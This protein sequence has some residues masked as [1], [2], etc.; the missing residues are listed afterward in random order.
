MTLHRLAAMFVASALLVVI[1][2]PGQSQDAKKSDDPFAP[3]AK[4]GNK[5]GAWGG[6]IPYAPNTAV[7]FGPV[8]CPVAVI[9][10]DVWDFKA[11]KV[12]G[13]VEAPEGNA[14]RALSADGKY[15]AAGSKSP[16]QTD[17]TV[18]VWSTET[19]KKLLDI[20]G[21]KKAYVDVL[22]FSRDKY[23]LLDG[24]HSQQ[25]DVWDIESGKSVKTLTVPDRRVAAD[26]LAFT[27]DGKFFACIAHDKLIVTDTATNKQAGVM[28]PPGPGVAPADSPKVGKKPSPLDA[29]FA[30]TWTR[31]LA[32]SADGT[33]LAAFS[34]HPS[35]RLLV[36][37]A[38]GELAMDEPVP[39]PMT[40][41][42]RN[43]L[44]WLPDGSGWLVNGYLFDRT[45]KRVVMSIRVPFASD[46]L[47]HL[48][49]KDHIIGVF[50]DDRS[51]LRTVT[52]P[53]DKLNASLK[54]LTAK[55]PAY[56][57]PGEAVSLDFEL[58]GL[59]GDEADTRKV[60]ADA[61]TRRLTRD[62]IPVGDGKTTVLKFRLTE[63]AGD[64]LPIYERQS[65]FDFK[66]KDTGRKATEAKGAA[67][68]E[69]VVK[70][71]AT[72]LWR[73]HLT[74]ASARSF[75]EEITDATVRKSMLEHLTRQLNGMDMPYFIPKSKDTV[76]LPAVVE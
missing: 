19:G 9:G 71:E 74:A 21:E 67:V 50:G 5:P 57:T 15:F 70:G 22:S 69:I 26:K 60:L 59:R 8:G 53:W 4:A 68:L 18:T 1:A 37:N 40:I 39:M 75:K 30:Y 73:G 3:G 43:T 2:N 28:A 61:L 66:G 24:R 7:T 20:P 25:L 47:P 76:A 12:V 29:I 33:E 45:S 51:R 44:E 36:W 52:V 55:A 41:S 46:V 6:T 35:P 54:Q 63:E 27:P 32:F 31:S 10:K 72:P 65:P 49:D 62:G 17:T 42:H 23:L 13:K 11:S 56:L 34:T 64:T 38:K 58:T 14:L 48:L 16:N